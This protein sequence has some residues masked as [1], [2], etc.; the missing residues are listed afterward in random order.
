MGHF[1]TDSVA[2]SEKV[3]VHFESAED[4][5]VMEGDHFEK[6]AVH[7]GIVEEHLGMEGDH[8]EIE[9]AVHSETEVGS[10]AHLVEGIAEAAQ[11]LD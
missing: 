5:F 1:E 6:A 4:L 8:S 2:R 3:A 10:R 9:E 7:F 11:T